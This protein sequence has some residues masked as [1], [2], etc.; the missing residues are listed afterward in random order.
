[1]EEAC[2]IA[3]KALTINSSSIE[4]LSIQGII[5]EE[6]RRNSITGGKALSNFNFSSLEEASLSS[7]TNAFPSSRFFF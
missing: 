1:M 2:S 5:G 4:S 6:E 3:A 7:A